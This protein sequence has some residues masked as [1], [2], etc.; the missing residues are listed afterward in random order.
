MTDAPTRGVPR[1]SP[2]PSKKGLIATGLVAAIGVVVLATVMS[3]DT[4]PEL[5][6]LNVTDS[7][8]LAPMS[9]DSLPDEPQ[10]ADQ[11]EPETPQ[12]WN[13]FKVKS[14]ETLEKVFK[15]AGL[16]ARDVYD[17]ISI[18]DESAG[19]KRLYPGDELL[20]DVQ[21]G[22][23]QALQ[24]DMSESQRLLISRT[25]EGLMTQ[26]QAVPIERKTR[27]G[28]GH[29]QDSLFLAGQAAGLSDAVIMR[30][31]TVFGWDIDFALDIRAGDSFFVIYEDLYREGE[32]VRSGEIVAATFVNRGKPF[33]AVRYVDEA[34]RTDYYTPDGRNMRKAF[35]RS[36]LDV[37]RVTSRFTTKRFHPVLKRFRAH[38]GV[39]Y[40][41]RPGTPVKSTGDGKVIFAG[42]NN[43]Y[44]NHVILQH[45]SQYKTLY[46]HFSRIAVKRGAR[47][48]Q[49]QTIGYSGSTG[50]V[51]APHLHYEF[52]VNDV[53]KDP[54]KV[55][56]P[57][58]EPLPASE[59][60]R[61]KE[62]SKAL[63]AQLES[64]ESIQVAS[65]Q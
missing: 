40:R 10:L 30:L 5:L 33:R 36:P 49:G 27:T 57:K 28:E 50:L 47:V 59:M 44:G 23:L 52:R 18:N 25:D 9:A 60:K 13:A 35:L 61:F 26:V 12:Q 17:V 45:G 64:F 38:R 42:K 2:T 1:K 29:I 55:K 31:A 32:F 65:A 41:A 62:A 7:L 11:L 15:R 8:G 4:E 24:Y 34:G 14:G 43:S 21:E 3:G 19:L 53:H 56:F 6:S 51:T 22:E 63:L 39:D 54:L 46:A 48:S 16:G 58:A 37:T 20:L